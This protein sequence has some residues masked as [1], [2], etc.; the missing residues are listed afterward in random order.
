M[1]T[2][3][4]E[5]DFAEAEL[6]FELKIFATLDANIDL[7]DERADRS[8]TSTGAQLAKGNAKIASA[9]A[10]TFETSTDERAAL[11]KRNRLSTGVTRFLAATDAEQVVGQLAT[12]TAVRTGI[13]S[14]RATLNA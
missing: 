14:H 9:D 4:S 7:A 8:H 3:W 13:A 5:C 6:V 2:T 10:D 11:T 12:L 1:L